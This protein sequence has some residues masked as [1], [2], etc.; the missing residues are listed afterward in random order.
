MRADEKQR[1]VSNFTFGTDH[2]YTLAQNISFVV[3]VIISISTD[4]TYIDNFSVCIFRF[5]T[6]QPYY[7]GDHEKREKKRN[8]KGTKK[9]SAICL[10]SHD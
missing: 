5:R 10:N 7:D 2:F 3:V 4:V 6:T 9:I 1:N 8:E